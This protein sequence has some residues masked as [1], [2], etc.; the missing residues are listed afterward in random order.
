MAYSNH[1]NDLVLPSG[2]KLRLDGSSSGTTYI[3]KVGAGAS[4]TITTG[5]TSAALELFG[6]FTGT[7]GGTASTH[8]TFGSN[9][10]NIT[11]TN[12]KEP[13]E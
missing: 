2:T 13:L 4:I 7:G 6:G 12:D 8:T 11:D 5:G 10:D 9:N 3:S 1:Y